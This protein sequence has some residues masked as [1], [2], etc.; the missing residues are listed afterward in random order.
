MTNTI[1][2]SFGLC[3]ISLLFACQHNNRETHTTVV[4]ANETDFVCGMKVQPEFTDTCHYDGKVYAFCS[5]SC[6]EEFQS[7]PVSYLSQDTG[8]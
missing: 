7:N 1:L 3:F 8:H 6:K 2:R 5:A 4:Y